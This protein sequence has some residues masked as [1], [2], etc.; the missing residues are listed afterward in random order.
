MQILKQEPLKKYTSFQIGG[1]ADIYIP[2]SV[3]ELKEIKIQYPGAF[4][5]GGGTK[6]LFPDEGLSVPVILTEEL[7]NIKEADEE[8][9]V[10]TGFM[11]AKLFD[12]AAG[13]AVTAGGA[14]WNNFGAFG[15]EIGPFVKKVCVLNA[16]EDQWLSRQELSFSYRNSSLKEKKQTILEVVFN[17]KQDKH[18]RSFLRQR[19]EK[20]PLALLSA[21]SVFKNPPGHFA[22]KLIE[23]CGLKGHTIGD[24]QVWEKHAN[25]II[26][27]GQAACIDVKTLV[28]KIRTEVKNKFNIAMDLELEIYGG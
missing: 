1:P 19:Q 6:M 17:K 4:I 2:E 12:F 11:I 10:G 23:D 3:E 9:I 7:K 26:N 5:L 21:G 20:Q 22:G 28:E 18:M 27:K 14:L 8:I 25:F 15:Y 24:A 16:K 13:I